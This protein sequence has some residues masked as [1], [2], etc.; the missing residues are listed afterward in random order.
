MGAHKIPK[1]LRAPA[2]PRPAID[3]LPEGC[4]HGRRR[5]VRYAPETA[6]TPRRAVRIHACLDC[7]VH[8]DDDRLDGRLQEHEGPRLDRDGRPWIA[9]DA[10]AR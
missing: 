3:E 7:G 4:R 6:R 10:G 5:F 9:P 1:P 2:T 8:L